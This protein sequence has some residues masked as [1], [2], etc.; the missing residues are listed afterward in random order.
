[1]VD[2]TEN[3]VYKTDQN[4][5]CNHGE[6]ACNG[7]VDRLMLILKGKTFYDSLVFQNEDGIL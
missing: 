4:K 1:M 7:C 3:G 2:E 6:I 5:I